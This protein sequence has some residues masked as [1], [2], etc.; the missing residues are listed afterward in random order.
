[1]RN[2]R[3][4]DK[5]PILNELSADPRLLGV[6]ALLNPFLNK[7]SA[8]RVQMNLSHTIQALPVEGAEMAQIY[9]GYENNLKDYWINP[10][11]RDQDVQ[12]IAQIPKYPVVGGLNYIAQSPSITVIYIGC[13]DGHLG[14]FTLDRY[15]K[16]AAGFGYEY[17]W[18]NNHSLWKEGSYIPKDT[19]LAHCPSVDGEKV[20][21]G[22]NANVCYMTVADTIQDSYPVSQ[23]FA[24]KLTVKTIS[25][26]TMDVKPTQHPINLYGDD[27]VFKFIPDVGE[28]VNEYGQLCA[29]R[30]INLNTFMADVHGDR[31]SEVQ[32]LHDLV[33]KVDPLSTVISIDYWPSSNREQSNT[34]VVAQME[35]YLANKVEYYK[36]ILDVYR[37]HKGKPLTKPMNTL[38]TEAYTRLIALG[39]RVPKLDRNG[40]YGK[41]KLVNRK[42]NPIE[43]MQI[44]VTI[45]NEYKF[46]NGDKIT[47][48][49]G[50][51]GVA[52]RIYPTEQ[53]PVD[54][55]GVR[56]DIIMDPGGTLKRMNTGQFDES[57]LNRI[58]EFVRRKMAEVYPTDPDEAGNILFEYLNDIFPYYANIVRNQLSTRELVHAY[59]KECINDKIHVCI[60]PYLKRIQEDMFYTKLKDKWNVPV[61]PVTYTVSSE[62]NKVSATF[63]TDAP[64]CIGGEYIYRLCKVPEPS[65]PGVAHVGH[66][67]IPVKKQG[68]DAKW[69][70]HI[71]QA[72][73]RFGE[74]EERARMV[75]VDTKEDARLM[76]LQGGSI[77]G[78][79]KTIEHILNSN[80]PTR[81]NR[82]PID[83]ET[84]I[85]TNSA[86]TMLRH[87][88]TSFGADIK[89]TLSSEEELNL[90]LSD[91]ANYEIE[92]DTNDEDAIVNKDDNEDV[93]D[94]MNENIILGAT[95]KDEDDDA[96]SA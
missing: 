17:V 41:P 16:A 6:P 34:Q 62:D 38:V 35:K 58:S 89:N 9:T 95:I 87:V 14:Y 68:G 56:A 29:F 30:H 12:V 18:N 73:T 31:L 21:L 26:I 28:T 61:T 3:K 23:A 47:N 33:Y 96:D 53:M 45:L 91:D 1:M 22:V 50:G 71:K 63:T 11:K 40:Q 15:Y 80:D 32:D 93:D 43:V 72:P 67:G 77:H 27:I 74:D 52:C 79:E 76:S 8:S 37:A 78:V 24:D 90:V 7:A 83:N 13:D 65:S 84:L 48:R 88:F 36:R 20:M 81:I 75:E 57:G 66:L 85:N 60:P 82:I 54:Q 46:S 92:D 5:Y 25:E 10:S 39:H 55:N 94:D 2:K 44:K 42:D 69:Q 64:V 86:V 51:K 70:S 4:D 19:V 49:H 59:V